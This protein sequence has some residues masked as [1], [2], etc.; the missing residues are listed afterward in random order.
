MSQ[1]EKLK[2]GSA[3]LTDEGIQVLASTKSLKKLS[4]SGMRKITLAGIERL[5][6][7]RPELI[8]EVR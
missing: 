1:F 2:I 4:L 7:A 8:I 6:Q 3:Q 5:R